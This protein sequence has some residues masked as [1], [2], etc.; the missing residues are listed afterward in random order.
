MV[1]PRLSSAVRRATSVT[2]VVTFIVAFALVS[3]GVGPAAAADRAVAEKGTRC[4][5]I[6]D[7]ARRLACYDAD[8]RTAVAPEKT[9]GIERRM[10]RDSETLDKVTAKITGVTTLRDGAL[11]VT[12]DN[13]QVWRQID[14]KGE[15][16]WA[17]G[18]SL[19]IERAALG[20][21]LA[22]TVGSSRAYRIR[23]EQ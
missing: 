16:H 14:R 3:V 8:F 12:L 13:G 1:E 21:F 5:A 23:R 2:A 9:F 18:D 19:V 4:A 22:S 7:D 17:V 6:D 10:Q 11:R 15:A 20:S